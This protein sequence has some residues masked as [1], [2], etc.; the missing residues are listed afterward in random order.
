MCGGRYEASTIA[1]ERASHADA[2]AALRASHEELATLSASVDAILSTLS[3][4]QMPSAAA[5]MPPAR[6][7]LAGVEELRES[8]RHTQCSLSLSALQICTTPLSDTAAVC[9]CAACPYRY[10]II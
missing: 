9:V 10:G 7:A 5:G 6:S 1:A 4:V 8:P 2:A 3:L